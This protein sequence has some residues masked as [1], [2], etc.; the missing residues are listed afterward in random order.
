MHNKYNIKNMDRIDLMSSI[1]G[2]DGT[3]KKEN[4]FVKFRLL[5]LILIG[6][7]RNKLWG[8]IEE[9]D[10][11]EL[12]AVARRDMHPLQRI[13]EMIDKLGRARFFFVMDVQMILGSNFLKRLGG[14]DG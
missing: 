4:W 12:N 2:R 3:F 8:Q 6:I 10:Y 11:R 9:I 5:W 1:K 7:L 13:E 14:S